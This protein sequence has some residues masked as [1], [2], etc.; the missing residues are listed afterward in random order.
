MGAD[1]GR[2]YREAQARPLTRARA[3]GTSGAADERLGEGVRCG[4]ID[5]RAGVHDRERRRVREPGG[6][7]EDA[8][9]RQVVHDGVAH[10][11][12]G[13][14][15][16]EGGVAGG[17]GGRQ[18]EVGRANVVTYVTNE[19]IACSLWLDRK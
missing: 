17:G 8:T 2:D 4:R 10:E 5:V 13:Q 1:E 11:I 7:D 19:H 9:A 6:G 18:V 16:G 14:A 3:A 12:G 15:L